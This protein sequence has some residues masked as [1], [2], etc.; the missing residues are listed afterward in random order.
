MIDSLRFDLCAELTR[1]E[2]I[3]EHDQCP[4]GTRACLSKINQKPDENDRVVAVIPLAQNNN[5]NPSYSASLSPKHLILQLHGAEYPSSSNSSLTRQSLN[6][7]LICDPQ[8]TS[9]P[10]FVAYDGSTLDLKWSGPA[11]CPFQ[12]E[13]G[14]DKDEDG[15]DD[16]VDRDKEKESVGSGIYLFLAFAA[17]LGLGAYYNYST[18]GATGYDLIPHRDFWKEM[19][20]MLSDVISHLCS[21]VRPRRTSSRGGYISV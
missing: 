13:S 2:G 7:T 3:P 19:P 5:L 9:D 11:G 20:Y 15:G 16:G 21:D 4:S 6:L 14:G 10:E 12:E 8:A 17:Y 1:Q 18:Y